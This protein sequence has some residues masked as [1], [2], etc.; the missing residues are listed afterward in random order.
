MTILIIIGISLLLIWLVAIVIGKI[1]NIYF[2][3]IG[4]IGALASII[5]GLIGLIKRVLNDNQN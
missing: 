2:N 1:D 3:A 5:P 4:L